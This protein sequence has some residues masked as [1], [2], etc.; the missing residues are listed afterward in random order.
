VEDQ[1]LSQFS[2]SS[3]PTFAVNARIVDPATLMARMMMQ[4]AGVSLRDGQQ[5]FIS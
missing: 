5:G 2:N 1:N 4:V 3:A